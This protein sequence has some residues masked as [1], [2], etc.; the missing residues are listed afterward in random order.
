MPDP[1]RQPTPAPQSTPA[2]GTAA[3]GGTEAGRV[4]QGLRDLPYDQ[5]RE[6]LRP[7]PPEGEPAYIVRRGD[8]L[9]DLAGRYLGS[10]ARWRE[11]YDANRGL[12]PNPNALQPGVRLSI[13]GGRGL[14]PRSAPRS[15]GGG[16]PKGSYVPPQEDLDMAA[17]GRQ[18]VGN[19][20]VEQEMAEIYNTKGRL[21][22]AEAMRLGI[23]PGVGGSVL[24]VESQGAGHMDGR[25]TIRFEP[26]V[27]RDESRGKRVSIRRAGQD[28][29]YA[30]FETARALNEEAA[31]RSIS[32]GAGQIMGFNHGALGYGSA[33]EMF[34]E[35]Q[36]S[37][38]AQ[39]VGVFEFIRTNR[40]ALNAAKRKNWATFAKHYNGPDYR[41]NQYDTKLANA[42]AAWLR[43]TRGLPHA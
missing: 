36:R 25:M 37:Q 28:E 18:A 29:E 13:P 34:E 33:R 6:A 10:A 38:R 30:A 12:I 43:V 20:P 15:E 22:H 21:V 27:F 2:R 32:M 1:A 7:P 16:T 42:Y 8:T 14:P 19:T 39:L 9:S 40:V 3:A 11:I 23:E 24:K 5:A 17:S 41:A 26:H 35:F 4:S 31:Y